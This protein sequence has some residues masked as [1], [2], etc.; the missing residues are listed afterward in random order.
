MIIGT[1]I[2]DSFY[3]FIIIVQLKKMKKDLSVSN[4]TANKI[5]LTGSN[6]ILL[7]S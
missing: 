2:V 3:S 1:E 7:Q 6:K 5:I 4:I